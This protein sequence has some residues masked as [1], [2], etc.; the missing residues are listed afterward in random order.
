MHFRFLMDS[1]QSC[2]PFPW[3]QG[4]MWGELR[5][6]W[7]QPIIKQFRWSFWSC[8]AQQASF[9]QPTKAGRNNKWTILKLS[10]LYFG[11]KLGHKYQFLTLHHL[12]IHHS[13]IWL[14]PSLTTRQPLAYLANIM[15]GSDFQPHLYWLPSACTTKSQTWC[16]PRST[17]SSLI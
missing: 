4:T 10:E 7:V 15:S 3:Q 11:G 8:Q 12:P 14:P 6:L 9:Q 16:I 13:Q 17:H 1:V 2:L 5:E